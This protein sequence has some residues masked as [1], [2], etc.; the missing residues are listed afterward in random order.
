MNRAD[1]VI[2]S[3]AALRREGK[4]VARVRGLRTLQA[5]LPHSSPKRPASARACSILPSCLYP[6]VQP[7]TAACG[8]QCAHRLLTS[9]PRP[10][11]AVLP[12]L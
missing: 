10:G 3:Q 7:G 12:L 2:E 9:V 11:R 8:C 6:A 5:L 1:D 4:H